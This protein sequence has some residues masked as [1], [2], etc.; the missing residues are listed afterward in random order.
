MK[1]LNTK[2]NKYIFLA[3]LVSFFSSILFFGEIITIQAIVSVAEKSLDLS[4]I[5]IIFCLSVLVVSY[6]L[7]YVRLR[8]SAFCSYLI[9]HDLHFNLN[10]NIFGDESFFFRDDEDIDNH[11]NILVNEIECIIENYYEELYNIIYDMTFLFIGTIYLFI[12]NYVIGLI[13]LCFFIASVIFLL[14]FSKKNTKLLENSNAYQ[15]KLNDALNQS[16]NVC[17]YLL[18]GEKEFE[19]LKI[20]N[21]L[22][23]YSKA[24]ENS[25]FNLLFIQG[26]N[27][28][29][30]ILRE[31]TTLFIIYFCF[32]SLSLSILF[33]ILY[34]CINISEPFKQLGNHLHN[35]NLTRNFRNENVLKNKTILQNTLKEKFF[36][37]SINIKNLYKYFND[38]KII[39]NFS[40]IFQKGNVYFLNGEN[41]SGKSTLL[42]MI[43]GMLPYDS[44]Q[45]L[46]NKTP[47]E[48][49]NY[50]N[51]SYCLNIENAGL[52]YGSVKEN[53]TMFGSFSNDEQQYLFLK[54]KI[55]LFLPD[56]Y[57]I[58]PEK[59]NVSSG[60]T[61]K[62][63]VL[64][65]LMS[66]KEL[67]IFDETFSHIDS[68]ST[69]C[70]SLIKEF[71]KNHIFIIV[72]HAKHIENGDFDFEIEI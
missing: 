45:I 36:Y 29:F 18:S 37:N 28:C 67:V 3:L 35:I 70:F 20:N 71:R 51:I 42:K 17:E 66:N 53:I 16:L 72:S 30:S 19:Q 2:S 13:S 14:F 47:L 59:C 46:Y 39:D 68:S 32:N 57:Q 31:I 7:Y 8:M 50:K 65:S 40:Y 21:C 12:L 48:K 5:L 34:F 1:N 23:E 22:K 56:D 24:K 44:G 64:R 55:D 54:E 61:Q 49:L 33:M 62:I 25:D 6:L 9:R 26:F 60:E 4:S 10:K 43:V 41:G 11:M 63:L 69:K 58:D 38:K 15:M 27:Y 52:F